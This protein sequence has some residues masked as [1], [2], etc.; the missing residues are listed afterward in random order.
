MGI[1]MGNMIE[2]LI[3][4]NYGNFDVTCGGNLDG[5]LDENFDWN[6]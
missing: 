1:L 5:N 2:I 4:K 3:K 6:F